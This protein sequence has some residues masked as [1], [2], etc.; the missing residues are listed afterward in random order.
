MDVRIFGGCAGYE[1]GVITIR[2]SILRLKTDAVFKWTGKQ[3][4]L[5]TMDFL[6]GHTQRTVRFSTYINFA[7]NLEEYKPRTGR[8]NTSYALNFRKTL[9][10]QYAFSHEPFFKKTCTKNFKLLTKLIVT[11]GL[12]TFFGNSA[13]LE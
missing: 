10:L 9:D 3:N 11:K 8:K 2:A 12:H 13:K 1:A 5:H 4:F 6:E 7:S